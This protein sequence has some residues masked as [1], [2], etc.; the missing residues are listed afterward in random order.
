MTVRLRKRTQ[1]MNDRYMGG[2]LDCCSKQVGRGE[3]SRQ[4]A[5]S[6]SIQGSRTPIV[7]HIVMAN[8]PWEKGSPQRAADGKREQD[9]SL[10]LASTAAMC[11]TCS[12]SYSK[13]E[14]N[15]AVS[16]SPIFI[17]SALR[18][19]GPGAS[20]SLSFPSCSLLPVS[21]VPGRKM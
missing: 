19:K 8:V 15:T 3:Y 7:L 6:L 16:P 12:V 13:E 9:K 17:L 10:A 18:G 11:L 20:F 4:L 14:P 1:V 21:Y 2:P 5:R